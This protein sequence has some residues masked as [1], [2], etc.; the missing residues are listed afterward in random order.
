MKKV[1]IYSACVFLLL[2]CG[3]MDPFTKSIFATHTGAAIGNVAGS[4]IGENIGGYKGS[5]V[6]SMLGTAAGAMIG[7]SV[8][9][10]D[11]QQ[12]E[13]SRE[14][15]TSPSPNLSIRDIRL[16]DENWNRIVDADEN[17]VL[18]FEIY[19]DGERTASDVRPVLKG[20]KGTQKLNYSRPLVIDQIKPGEGVL[21]KVNISASSNVKS[22]EA[23]FEIHL[24]ERNG[25]GTPREEFTIRT[26]EK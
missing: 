4:I 10:R 14:I 15:I 5:F 16:Q 19:N 3:S 8:V 26:Q 11:Q 18:I 6:G 20:L 22:G 9:A 17:C 7:A 24:E 13:R 12:T 2:G 21:Y 1:F 25:F 23:V